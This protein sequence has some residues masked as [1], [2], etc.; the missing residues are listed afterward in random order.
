VARTMISDPFAATGHLHL[1]HSASA[2][3]VVRAA[4]PAGPMRVALTRFA[5]AVARALDDTGRTVRRLEV[6]ARLGP[7]AA[8]AGPSTLLELAVRGQVAALDPGEFGRLA[9]LLAARWADEQLPPA[10]EPRIVAAAVEPVPA[11]ATAAPAR[12]PRPGAAPARRSRPARRLGRA[13][14]LARIAWAAAIS[15]A[16]LALMVAAPPPR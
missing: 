4:P 2:E 12:D 13:R 11:P 14:R 15:C 1:P 7:A 16:S 3:I 9:R 8:A 5:A 10:I 6:D